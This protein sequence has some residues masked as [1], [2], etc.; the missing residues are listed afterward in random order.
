MRS[1][2]EKIRTKQRSQES[3][4]V[5]WRR[6]FCFFFRYIFG[7]IKFMFVCS[8]EYTPVNGHINADSVIRVSKQSVVVWTIW[9]RTTPTLWSRYGWSYPINVLWWF[10]KWNQSKNAF[11][12]AFYFQCT[13][14]D[15]S[16][17]S[18]RILR[19]H[20][21][22]HSEKSFSCEVCLKKFYRQYHLKSHMKVHQE[23]YIYNTIEWTTQ[24]PGFD[25]VI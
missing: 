6:S 22:L 10:M 13:V 18:D 12:F 3:F 25:S 7:S 16:F 14:C 8:T 1:L 21:R 19:G 4:K 20:M 17:K 2:P 9:R 24:K 15:K 11:F 23:Y 5:N